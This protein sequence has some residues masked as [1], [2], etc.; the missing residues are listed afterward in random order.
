MS[1]RFFSL[2]APCGRAKGA[3]DLLRFN[4]SIVHSIGADEEHLLRSGVIDRILA[5]CGHLS[6]DLAIGW[7]QQR[8][9]HAVIECAVVGSVAAAA[10]GTVAVSAYRIR[11]AF[12]SILC[13]PI[14][15]HSSIDGSSFPVRGVDAIAS[16]GNS[17]RIH[18]SSVCDVSFSIW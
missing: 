14:P 10:G 4:C 11:D 7:Q 16:I 8:R 15:D 2:L 17:A 3:N 9:R 1:S 18:D 5:N 13:E 12:Y 6:E